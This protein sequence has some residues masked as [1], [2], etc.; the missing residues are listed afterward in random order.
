MPRNILYKIHP[1]IP[2]NLKNFSG[3]FFIIDSV[4]IVVIMIISIWT[5]IGWGIYNL[6]TGGYGWLIFMALS[7]I[8]YIISQAVENYDAKVSTINNAKAESE[9]VS[10]QLNDI[11]DKSF[12]IV[13]K[14]LPY[15]EASAIDSIKKAKVDISKK[16][17]S[18]FWDKIEEAN[19]FLGFYKEAVEQLIIN[20][21]IYT[22][23]LDGKKHN[24]PTPFPIGTNISIPQNTFDEFHSTIY[25]AHETDGFSNI[26]EHRKTQKI[27]ITGFKNLEQAINKMC[28]AITAAISDLK[29]S[30][31][32]DFREMRNFQ[33]EQL[34]SFNSSQRTMTETLNEMNNKLYYIQYNKKPYRPFLRPLFDI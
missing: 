6:F 29:H 22:R 33:Q 24:F 5:T 14:I 13:E 15:F 21:E 2:L 4:T 31:K 9:L 19:N 17:I 16:A 27:L 8:L 23:T 32:S 18:P 3:G 28:S 1:N 25:T 10:K 26:W 20:G 11:L 12:E 7:I 30:I 34:N